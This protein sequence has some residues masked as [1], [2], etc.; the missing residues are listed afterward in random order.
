MEVKKFA[1]LLIFALL[2]TACTPHDTQ[3]NIYNGAAYTC[4]RIKSDIYGDRHRHIN[5]S[6]QSAITRA[7]LTQDYYRYGCNQVDDEGFNA[8]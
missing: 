5:N 7:Q 1:L 8:W 3:E 4:T 6:H 2:I